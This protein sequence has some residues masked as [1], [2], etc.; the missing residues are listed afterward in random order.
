VGSVIRTALPWTLALV[1]T[2]TIISFVVGTLLGILAA[3]RRGTWVD[4]L[5]PVSAFFSA[6]PYFW[7]GAVVIF[8]F[9]EKL[10]WLPLSGAYDPRLSPSFTW[11]FVASALKYGALP[12]ATIVVSSISGWL[13]GMRNVMLL[14]IP[15][16]Y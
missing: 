3:W 4:H 12:A 8:I 15:E 5:L 1:G 9:A 11:P 10:G 13:L 14:A 2:A 6:I 16:D 7:L